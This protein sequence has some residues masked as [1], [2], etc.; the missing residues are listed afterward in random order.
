MDRHRR[1]RFHAPALHH[2]S[3]PYGGESKIAAG[4]AIFAGRHQAER[5]MTMEDDTTRT[6]I[7]RV[8]RRALLV[9]IAV[10]A[11]GPALG[12]PARWAI[13]TEYPENSMPG[14]GLRT[15]AALVEARANGG[16]LIAPSFNNELGIRSADMPAAIRDHRVLAAD[17]FGGGLGAVQP[18]FLLSS[19]PFVAPT[20]A[21][22]RRL[23]EAAR[24][25]YD[26]AL[27]TMNARILYTTP[28]PPTGIWSK[29]PLRTP[30]DLRGLAI[31]TY[32]STGTAVFRAL[33]AAPEELSFPD[34]MPR[35]ANGTI[36]AVLSSGDGGAGRRLWEFLP[37][38]VAVGYAIPLSFTIVGTD[39]LSGVGGLGPVVLAAGEETE[40]R[41][42]AL[43]G[44]RLEEN[45]ARMRANRVNIATD[46]SPEL[47]DAL[48]RAAEGAV[49]AWAQQAGAD[50]A[51]ILR[52]YQ[53]R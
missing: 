41:Q 37:N 32:D 27:A 11:A 53:G 6:A 16:L 8:S 25:A 14:E 10:L 40:R 34:T 42:W 51:A 29:A 3:Q 31:R 7:A 49:A 20:F 15:F 44:S 24:P 23:Y 35:L 38:F 4:Q 43:V 46:P 19:L 28:W 22:A 1:D 30:A 12:Q 52:R 13:P 17:A 39:A 5:G 2:R 36:T 48:A 50:G 26:A 45:Y 47:R 21:D 33:G 18:I 9:A